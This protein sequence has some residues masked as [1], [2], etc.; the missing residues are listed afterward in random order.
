MPVSQ[1]YVAL[2][3]NRLR[4]T[5]S[6]ESLPVEVCS[7]LDDPLSISGSF[8]PSDERDGPVALDSS[9]IVGQAEWAYTL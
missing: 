2:H 6:L 5:L 9:C 7:L 1:V 4:Q 3:R 8:E